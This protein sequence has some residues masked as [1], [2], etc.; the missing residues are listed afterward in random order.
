MRVVGFMSSPVRR[1][2]NGVVCAT[3]FRT[4]AITWQLQIV[5]GRSQLLPSAWLKLAPQYTF[6]HRPNPSSIIYL[7]FTKEKPSQNT[8]KVDVENSGIY[9]KKKRKWGHF[10]FTT[11]AP[12]AKHV[13]PCLSS[14]TDQQVHFFNA[15]RWDNISDQWKILCQ[16]C[17][18]TPE[19][20]SAALS[21]LSMSLT[22]PPNL[23]LLA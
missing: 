6:H 4:L 17:R 20:V 10:T 1:A 12:P 21:P 5:R 9:W 19:C 3:R 2:I 22:D 14:R 16:N 18:L 13:L 7:L 11:S 23:W 15:K 8:V